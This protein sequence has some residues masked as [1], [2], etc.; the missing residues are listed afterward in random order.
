MLSRVYGANSVPLRR[1]P[2]GR[3][4]DGFPEGSLGLNGE[5]F[6]RNGG[7]RGVRTGTIR[8]RYRTE[9]EAKAKL[10]EIKGE[11]EERRK[12]MV[13]SMVAQDNQQNM[14]NNNAQNN[15]EENV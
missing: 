10:Q 13:E 6:R 2:E 11:V 4:K 14:Q 8:A 9:D 12:Q 3:P 5:A 7:D 15:P 1:G